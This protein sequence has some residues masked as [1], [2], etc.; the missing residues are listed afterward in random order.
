[1]R[2][3]EVI[4]RR[5]TVWDVCLWLLLAVAVAVAALTR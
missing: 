5:V 3:L 4:L 2:A 1:M